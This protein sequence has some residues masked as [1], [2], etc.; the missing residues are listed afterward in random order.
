MFDF[1]TYEVVQ[2]CLAS[3]PAIIAYLTYKKTAVNRHYIV[4]IINIFF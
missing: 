1:T 3:I 2:I 4:L